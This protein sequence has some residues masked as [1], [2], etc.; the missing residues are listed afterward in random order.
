M[1]R[2]SMKQT[3]AAVI[4]VSVAGF[5]AIGSAAASKFF[6]D[7]PIWIERD[8]QDA[9]NVKPMEISLFVD[10]TSNAL[11]R[12]DAQTPGRA[13]NLNSVDELPDSSWFTNRAGRKPL[14]A[15][16]VEA[17]PDTSVGPA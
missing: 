5:T 15:A 2:T 16:E 6:D 8:T 3:A 14:T 10:I 12:I 1:T 11:R 9:S 17:G 4:V 13:Q 7:D